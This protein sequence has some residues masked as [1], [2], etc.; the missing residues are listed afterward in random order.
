MNKQ[1]AIHKTLI[2]KFESIRAKNPNY[3]RR[4]FSKRLGISAGAISELFN[5]QRKISYKIAQRIASRLNLDPQERAKLFSSF[6]KQEHNPPTKEDPEYLQLTADQFQVIGDWYHFAILT[7]MRTKGFCSDLKWI[8]DRLGLS[9]TTVERALL[10]L[11]RLGMV[12]EN[13]EQILVRSKKRFRTSDDI[14]NSSVQRAHHQYLEKAKEAL[15][16]LPVD[17]RD[18]TSLMLTFH[19]DQLP[20]AKEMIRKF[21]DD[22]SASFEKT[23]Q[24]EVYQL[25]IQLFPLTQPA[26]GTNH[27][28]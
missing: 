20:R 24:P 12:H 7:L 3:S 19:P 21:Q 13:E 25:C 9:A 8:G 14:T 10:R 5:G 6:S 2:S 28:L 16:P 11:K 18:L 17:S 22:F 23:P 1:I 15:V 4:A 27:E 26:K